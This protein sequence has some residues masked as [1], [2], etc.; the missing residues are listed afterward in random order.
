MRRFDDGGAPIGPQM[1]VSMT[2]ID[3]AYR[4]SIAPMIDGGFLLTWTDTRPGNRIRA[5]RFSFDG[6]KTGPE[7]GVNSVEGFHE[8]PVAI[9]LLDGNYVIAWRNDPSPAGG[10]ALIFRIFDLE[11]RPRTN[12]IRPN[13]SGFTGPKAMTLLDDGRFVIL[14]VRAGV[15]S[16]LGVMQSI[17]EANI[18][19]PSGAASNVRFTAT[20]GRGIN[21]A[22]PAVA[23]LPGGRLL[24]SWIQKSAETFSTS[25][26]VRARVLSASQGPLGQEI[27]ANSAVASN[28][29][30]AA[31]A[32]MFGSGEGEVAFVIWD[33]DSRSGGDVSETAVHGRSL[34]I[35]SA[36]L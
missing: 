33:D 3:P 8:A 6:A 10:G 32:T 7:L 25:P 22:W 19:Q 12:E 14:H 28:R 21:C 4:P 20:S 24:A 2:D 23:A 36:G 11:G 15:P 35:T 18:Y 16:D 30:N 9:R 27:Q 1:Q 29:F 26:T 34:R 17:V 5:Q 13:I 31:T